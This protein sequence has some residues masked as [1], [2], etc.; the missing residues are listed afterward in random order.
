MFTVS[1]ESGVM[2]GTGTFAEQIVF[3][4]DC[5]KLADGKTVK[6]EIE[7]S[8]ASDLFSETDGAKIYFNL[9]DKSKTSYEST[10]WAT[11]G[12]DYTSKNG[13]VTFQF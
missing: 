5:Q 10:S 1:R 3:E 13:Q 8:K 4:L 9:H 7:L 2:A 6:F 11:T 12:F